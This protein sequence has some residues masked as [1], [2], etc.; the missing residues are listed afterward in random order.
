MFSLAP[1]LLIVIS[2]A[3]LVFGEDAVRGELFAQLQ[4]LMGEDAAKA[5][6]GPARQRQQAGARAS[7]ATVVGVAVL[8]VGATTVFGELQDALDRI[9]RAPAR[10]KA[11]ASGRCCARACSRSA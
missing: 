7:S 5:V 10:D 4:G 9:W 8:L 11:A 2:V 1:L 3:G 6:A